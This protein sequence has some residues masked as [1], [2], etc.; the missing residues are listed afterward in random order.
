MNEVISSVDITSPSIS[1]W[2]SSEMMSMQISLPASSYRWVGS[3]RRS[4]TS[5][6]T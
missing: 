2:H 3:A 1:E 5:D 4:S 6:S